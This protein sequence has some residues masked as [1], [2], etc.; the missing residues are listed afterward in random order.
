MDMSFQHYSSIIGR[1]FLLEEIRLKKIVL[2]IKSCNQAYLHL[3]TVHDYFFFFSKI[4][5]GLCFQILL[6]KIIL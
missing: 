1:M 6:L 4:R 5:D 2:G 3:D